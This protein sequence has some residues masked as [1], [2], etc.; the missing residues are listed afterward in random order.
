MHLQLPF[1]CSF[2][3]L[4]VH[5]L[6]LGGYCL[7]PSSPYILSNQSCAQTVTQFFMHMLSSTFTKCLFK[8]LIKSFWAIIPAEVLVQQFLP[9]P[10]LTLLF[11]K[12]SMKNGMLAG[13]LGPLWLWVLFSHCTHSICSIF[14]L[15]SMLAGESPPFLAVSILFPLYKLSLLNLY[16]IW[17]ASWRIWTLSDCECLFPIVHTQPA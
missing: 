2:S 9:L 17:H 4:L 16:S 3:C 14:I 8:Q 5:I 6:T 13:K 10:T 12:I 7:S 1:C 15:S 11:K